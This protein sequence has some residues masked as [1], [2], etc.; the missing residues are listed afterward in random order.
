MKKLIIN[1]FRIGAL[2]SL[3]SLGS[4]FDMP[5]DPFGT[6]KSIVID[7]EP[8][9]KQAAF[10]VL[11]SKCNVCHKKQNPFKIFSLKNMEKHALKIY[12]QV[13]IYKRMPKGKEIQLTNK[14]YQT[15]ENWLKSKN[16]F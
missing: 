14:E 1:L 11:K 4:A 6:N 16:I 8:G 10:E 5:T 15:L 12:K 9:L 13:Y 3:F 7:P 2:L